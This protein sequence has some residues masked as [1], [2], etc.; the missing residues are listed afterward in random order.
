MLLSTSVSLR[1]VCGALLLTLVGAGCARSSSTANGDP[2]PSSQST[3]TSSPVFEQ[4][5]PADAARQLN[6]VVGNAILLH[7]SFSGGA[8]SL[9]SKW[10]WG[11]EADYTVIVKK[12][13]PGYFADV[14]WSRKMMVPRPANHPGSAKEIERQ[15]TGTVTGGV[16]QTSHD[17]YLPTLW[18]EGDHPA[19]GS[20]LLWLS[21]EEYENFAK[22][23]V[24]TFRFGFFEKNLTSAVKPNAEFQKLLTELDAETKKPG[25]KD[26]ALTMAELPS[27][28][29]LKINGKDVRVEVRKAKNWFGEIVFLNNPQNPLVLQVTL[30]KKLL[31]GKLDG[32]FDYTVTEIRTE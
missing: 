7:Q 14:A 24:S 12:F 1:I 26:V 25:V 6:L 23:N 16:L 2:S 15:L 29:P 5:A 32:L 3:T 8:Q 18:N 10:G 13:A 27:E 17:L 22:T 21:T 20:S 4:L 9:V 28:W 19:F 11:K 30:D 31:G